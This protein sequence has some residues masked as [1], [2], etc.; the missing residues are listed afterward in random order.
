MPSPRA[1]ALIAGAPGAKHANAAWLAEV[2]AAI[3]YR[4]PAWDTLTSREPGKLHPVELCRAL[5]QAFA[6]HPDAILVCDGGEIGQWPQAMLAPA[7][8]I[9]NGPAGSIG[10]SIPMAI[11][12][13]AAA[14][15][16]LP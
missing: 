4:P 3:A 2:R 6:R 15:R 16:T 12:A 7:R 11:A 5:Q 10:S 1:N 14:P 8:R 9:I 13:R